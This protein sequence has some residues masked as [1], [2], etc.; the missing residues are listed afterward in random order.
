MHWLPRSL[1]YE[2]S[3]WMASSRLRNLNSIGHLNC[4]SSPTNRIGTLLFWKV[5][6]VLELM[7]CD[8][9]KYLVEIT[10]PPWV[11]SQYSI[12]IWVKLQFHWSYFSTYMPT[13]FMKPL[14]DKVSSVFLIF[15]IQCSVMMKLKPRTCLV[16]VPTSL[17]FFYTNKVLV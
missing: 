17:L 4:S 11:H 9:R 7:L 12:K 2:K 13:S 14:A 5:L 1:C 10:D 16:I 3:L 8:L 15:R 6:M